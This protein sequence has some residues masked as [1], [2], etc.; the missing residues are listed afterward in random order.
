[1]DGA[2][3]GAIRAAL[4]AGVEV[5]EKLMHALEIAGDIAQGL[6]AIGPEVTGTIG[7][8]PAATAAW[9]AGREPP[10]PGHPS[11]HYLEAAARPHR[12]PVPCGLPITV[13]ERSWVVNTLVRAGLPVIV[14]AQLVRSLQ[15]GLGRTGTPAAAGLPPD[16]DTTAGTLYALALLGVPHEPD[17]L[18]AYETETH[19][20]TWPGE[21]GRSVSTNAHVLEAFG[22]YAA[23]FPG[24][25]HR[26][27]PTIARLS[28]WLSEQQRPDGS[29]TDR[30]HASPYYATLCAALALHGFGGAGAQAA[31]RRARQ[32]L[33]A[34]QR[35]DGS[36]GLWEGTAEETAYAVQILLLTGSGSEAEEMAAG[37]GRAHLLAGPGADGPAMWHDKDLYLPTAIVHATVLAA[38]HLTLVAAR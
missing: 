33:L 21:Q 2:T 18:W 28:T 7:A 23:G 34:T 10:E 14:P 30:W 8:S 4:A 35:A 15:A 32:W 13:F 37:R 36:W 38:L 1:V 17:M 11:R 31:V 26:Y 6:R 25:A 20:C 19:F 12:G 27:A 9:L 24:A 29:W 3:L 22:Q 16:A 5:P